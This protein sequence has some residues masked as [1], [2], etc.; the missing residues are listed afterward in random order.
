MFTVC[1]KIE[2]EIKWKKKS[3][4]NFFLF[5]FTKFI[6]IIL[7]YLRLLDSIVYDTKY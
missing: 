2:I 1:F 4:L 6:I 3:N 5:F 7:N